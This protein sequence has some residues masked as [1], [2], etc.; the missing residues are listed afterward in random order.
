MTYLVSQLWLY[1]LCAGLLGLLLGWVIWG[2]WG[3]RQLADARAS[4][5]QE[6]MTLERAYEAEKTSLQEDRADAF[7]ARD[8]ALK[9]KASMIDELESERKVALEAKTRIGHLIQ[10]EQKA[11]GEFERS[12]SS[13]Q[14]QLDKERSTATEAKKAVEAI[15]ADVQREL[16]D[17]E[18][19]LA[20][21]EK[22]NGTLRAK[23]EKLETEAREAE[24]TLKGGLEEERQAKAKLE[25]AL[26]QDRAELSEAKDRIEEVRAEM[27]REIQAKQAALTAANSESQL[28]AEMARSEITRLRSVDEKASVGQ[29]EIN[30]LRR[31]MQ[32]TIDEERQAKAAAVADRSRLVASE[33]EAVSEVE[34]LR[35]QL[36]SMSTSGEGDHAEALRLKRELEEAKQRQRSLDAEVTR[37]HGLLK[38]QKSAS[39]TVVA[40][41]KFT[42]DAPR[43]ASLFDRRPEQVDDLKDVKGIGPVMEGIL[44]ENGC[45]HFQQLANFSPRDIEWISQALGS[46]PDRIERDQW[47]RQA[48][49]LYFQ[50]YGKRHDATGVRNLETIS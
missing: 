38:E 20:S 32:Q 6:R 30:E 28:K 37:L 47:V 7:M 46:F 50:K 13:I 48:Q 42:T 35:S 31:T 36:S 5:E 25:A 29:S 19:S 17:R 43:P 9:V 21:S 14:G 49:T 39:A 40:T 3:R 23:L 18:A 2:W 33:R 44:N 45:Y 8:E 27:N 22:V 24:A 26:Q 34:R 4:Y 10:A 1:L 16:Q 15:R 11:K 41:P 12:L